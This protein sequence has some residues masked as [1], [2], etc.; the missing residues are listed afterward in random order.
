MSNEY[1]ASPL[2]CWRFLG[3]PF[4]ELLWLVFWLKQT[5]VLGVAMYENP[6]FALITVL[7]S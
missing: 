3:G 2:I 5:Q 4:G 1:Y 6:G 7:A